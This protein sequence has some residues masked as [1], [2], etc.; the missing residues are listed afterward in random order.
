[1]MVDAPAHRVTL[2]RITSDRG[3]RTHVDAFRGSCS[4]GEGSP[5]LSTAGMVAGW[6]ARHREQEGE[7]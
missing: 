4:C 5:R 1:M 6:D 7:L 2:V 3:G